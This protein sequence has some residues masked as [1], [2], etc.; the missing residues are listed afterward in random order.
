METNDTLAPARHRQDD[1]E[2][3]EVQQSK[4]MEQ[5]SWNE[6]RLDD[7]NGKVDALSRKVDK[8]FEKVDDEFKGLHRLIAYGAITMS[9]TTALGFAAIVSVM[10]A[11]L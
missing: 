6:A 11:K 1:A 4:A 3:F 8:R 9:S 10:L 7:L 5:P 2:V